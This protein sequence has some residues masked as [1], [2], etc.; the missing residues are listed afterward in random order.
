MHIVLLTETWIRNEDQALQFQLPYYTHYYNYRTDTTGG[1][2]SAYVHNNLKHSLSE[3]V[4]V[5][6][7]NYLWIRLEKYALEVGIVYNPGHTNFKQFLEVYE[8]QLQERR[9]AI[10]FG[11][12]NID[13][14]TK[15]SKTNQ[16]NQLLKQT[17]HTIINKITKKYCTREGSTKKSLLDHISTN[18]KKDNFHVITVNS[19]ISDHKQLYVEIKKIKPPPRKHYQYE[20]I[21]YKELFKSMERSEMRD[22]GDDFTKLEKRIKKLTIDHKVIKTKI[23]NEP[24]KEW[25]DRNIIAEINE[26][27]QM[28]TELKK[29]PDDENLKKEFDTKRKQVINLIR[30]TKKSYY[31]KEFEKH[32]GTPTKLWNMLNA[33]ANNKLKQRSVP[34]KLIVNSVEVSDSNE[35][36]KIFNNFF[37]TIGTCL[38]NEIPTSFHDN[39]IHALPKPT[40]RYSQMNY[41]EPCTEKEILTI[42]NNLD[43]NSSVGVDGIST[44]VIKCVKEL[45]K[46]RLTISFNKLLNDG[47]FPDSLKIA[48]VTPIY[49]S[50]TRTDPGNYRPISVLPILSKIF[51]K[52][53]HT[54]LL[55]YL[56]SINFFFDRQYGFRPKSNTLT[57]T[58]DLVTKIKHSI[59]NKNI[60]LGVFIDLKKAFDTVSHKLLLKKLEVIGIVGKALKMFES[61][62][63]NR[64]QIVKID[65]NSQSPPLP[66]SCGVPQGSILGPL[67]FLVYINNMHELGLNGNI[68]L[69][70]DDTCLFYFGSSIHDLI[71]QAQ[72]DLDVLHE[73]LQYNLLT[74][75]IS[76]T[77]YILFKAKNKLIPNYIPL[78]IN[79][80]PI[81]EKT[82][83]RYLGLHM[84]T[85]L[86][87][88]VHINHL[89]S[90]LLSLHAS[91][92][93]N[94]RCIPRKLRFTIYNSLIKS[95]LSYLIEIWG[96][97]AK[98]RLDK[99]QVLQNKIIKM[100]FNFKFRTST[101]KIYRETKLMSI[102]QLY[103]YSTCIFIRKTINK[104]VHTELQ[105]KSSKKLGRPCTRRASLIVLPKTRTKFGQTAITYDGARLYNKIPSD[106]KNI[107]SFDVF[108]K[109]L[110][111]YIIT[112]ISV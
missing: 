16:Y 49:K 85:Y 71:A 54:R 36:C 104:N 106:I 30:E 12:F 48:K 14:L 69:Y 40:L 62:L 37:A 84:D 58:I 63:E 101:K 79:N 45:I 6:G 60:V 100:L 23:V 25:I 29:N 50:G 112:K 75:N 41:F 51:E 92:R 88:N 102:K 3:S 94:V 53:I 55:N 17:G 2:V 56:N 68:T 15:N 97:T 108:K 20:A 96:S 21:N 57:A 7:N 83:E 95:H 111:H 5:G 72:Y 26:R 9:R 107:D 32:S 44:K 1:G 93:I 90:K 77:S 22:L 66:I 18:L 82:H 27:N 81:Q 38:A 28:W 59:D 13:L 19:S 47:S 65:S 76:K 42:I 24:Q 73:W 61:Y 99:L 39:Y 86:T 34:S 80:R 70:A 98:T 67:L 64:L 10:V 105:F 89:I 78:T 11:D 91:L 35:M 87:W 4:Y 8:S 103:N 46:N 33:L 74:I 110:Y 31:E 43:S 109:R 52:V